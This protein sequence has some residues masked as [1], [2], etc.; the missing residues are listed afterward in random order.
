MGGT[1]WLPQSLDR[2]ENAQFY[3]GSLK[4]HLAEIWQQ[5]KALIFC[6]AT[7]AVVR[8]IA[9]LLQDKSSDPAVVVV[10]GE[11]RF[12]IGLCSG[13]QGGADLLAQLIAQQLDATLIL[14]GASS[15][16]G[17]PGIDVLGVPY[18]WRKGEGD[19]TGV[20]AAI[21]RRETVQIIQEVGSTLWQE[22][23][24][25]EHPFYFGFPEHTASN[26]KESIAPKA[27]VW[28]SHTKR[29]FSSQ[30]DLPEVQ[31]HPR[32]LW[33]GIGCQRG[34]SCQLIETAIETVLPK[35]HLA[36]EAIAAIATIEI[37]AD[38]EGILELCRSWD[39]PLK[40]FS[41]EILSRVAVPNPSKIV[42]QEVGTPSV[43]EAAA[44]CASQPFTCSPSFLVPK[45]ICQQKGVPG[46]V[47]VAIARSQLEY[48][49]RTGKLYL[50]GTGSG[51][52]EQITPAAKTAIAQAD[53]VI[54]YSL[55]IDLIQPLFRP[56]QIIE[57]YKFEV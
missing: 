27:R 5:H 51:S 7:G 10:D 30:S 49:G 39:L 13:H 38:E 29:R 3:S 9:P 35:Y 18:G 56:G 14:T 1:L 41:A 46:A 19:W 17:L 12:A 2:I 33:V 52:L 16:L 37:K 22:H 36:R 34:T 44:I 50:V 8:S 24:P 47:T 43:A 57:S 31:W 32:V 21:S 6:L 23:L 25:Q 40:T 48:T 20:G 53:A 28:I 15:R 54:G 4:E 55:Y 11:G 45:Q 26:Q 42:S